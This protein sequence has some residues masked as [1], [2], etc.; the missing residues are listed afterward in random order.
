MSKDN[1]SLN[2]R[3]ELDKQSLLAQTKEYLKDH[4][5]VNRPKI[6]LDLDVRVEIASKIQNGDFTNSLQILEQHRDA[7][8]GITLYEAPSKNDNTTP[9]L[10]RDARNAYQPPLRYT[11]SFEMQYLNAIRAAIDI[12]KIEGKPELE[13]ILKQEA[14]TFVN[15]FHSD[16]ASLSQTEISK[17]CKEE[18]W[19]IA[20][21]LEKNGIEDSVNKLNVAKD[22]QNLNDPHKNIVTI[23]HVK[24][25]GMN[26]NTVIE[27]E[28]ALKGLTTAQKEQYENL[29]NQEWY[30][31]LPEWQKKLT[32]TYAPTIIKGNH[33][34]STQLRQ[35][36]GMSNAFEKLTGIWD[37]NDLKILHSAKH[38]GTL[39]SFSKDHKSRQDITNENSKQ[40]QEWIGPQ[41]R[42]HCVTFNSGPDLGTGTDRN[43]VKQTIEAM[44]TIKGKITNAAFNFLRF[45]GKANVYDGVHAV[46]KEIEQAANVD[47]NKLTKEEIKE[48]KVSK[49]VESIIEDTILLH[50]LVKKADVGLRFDLNNSNAEITVLQNKLAKKIAALDENTAQG[51][52]LNK[53]HKEEILNM[54]A[55]GKDRTGLAMHDQTV[56]A[57]AEH[58]NVPVK[59]LDAQILRGGHTSEQAGGVY[60]GGAS[61]GAFGTK[62]DNFQS[63]P[64]NRREE[65][66]GIIEKSA[67]GNKIKERSMIE[68][69]AQKT[70]DALGG[71]KFITNKT[72]SRNIGNIKKSHK[73]PK[74][75]IN[76]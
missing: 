34:K 9:I 4:P 42:L 19:K 64:W 66:K 27:A 72:G 65:L 62:S 5:T 47:I 26:N 7:K 69:L 51:L 50:N 18:I 2:E 23:S 11:E 39:A 59:D 46:I 38:A 75:L 20:D 36:P 29:D 25:D 41:F 37:S 53:L 68:K 55:S 57:I 15:T 56:Q 17:H 58:L 70:R 73:A 6:R 63:L 13:R 49:E 45:S 16:N 54:C 8:T 40:A 30:N 76:Y 22:F 24:T 14:I 3:F 32:T 21:L 31:A 67:H 48:L 71:T 60:A 12:A 10:I 33:V 28:V 61:I 52:D 35:I 44:H 74:N 1:I 43:I